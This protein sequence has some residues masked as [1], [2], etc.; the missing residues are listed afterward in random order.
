MKMTIRVIG[1][2]SNWTGWGD[3]RV[4]DQHASRGQRRVLDLE[5][6]G[7]LVVPRMIPNDDDW[8]TIRIM[9]GVMVMEVVTNP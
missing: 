9:F 4:G 2:A 3:E 1:W 7:R 6:L 8:A 5:R